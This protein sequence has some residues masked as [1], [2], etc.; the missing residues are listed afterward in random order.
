MTLGA[1]VILTHNRHALLRECVHAIRSQVDYVVIIDNASEPPVQFTDVG[2]SAVQLIIHDPLQPPNLALFMN[3]GFDAVARHAAEWSVAEWDVAT[4]CDDVV[5]PAGWF[6]AVRLPMRQMGAAA[7]STHSVSSVA[8]PLL[9]T[10]P[11][12]D[13]FNRMQGS[14]FVTRGELGLRAD[15]SLRWWWQD[16]DLDWQARA[17]GGTVI[18]PGPIAHNSRPNDFTY[19]VPGLADQSGQDGETFRTKWGWKPW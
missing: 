4:L 9:K 12:H 16:T 3:E 11:D 5:A 2:V 1:A 13:I 6:D 8:A 15:E 7:G 19:S 17:A 14:A 10:Q 18:T